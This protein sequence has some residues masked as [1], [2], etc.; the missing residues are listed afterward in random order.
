MTRTR[1]EIFDLAWNGLKAQGFVQSV[2]KTGSCVFRG[3]NGTRCAIGHCIPDD[4]YDPR[5][6]REGE[7]FDA[8]FDAAGVGWRDRIF[9]HNLQ[10]AHDNGEEPKSMERYLR[11]L[12][13]EY[14]LTIPSEGATK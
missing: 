2:N 5:M 1:Q 4:K 3:P 11:N 10:N 7:Y 8:A 13:G 9:A 12:A 14:G 6:D